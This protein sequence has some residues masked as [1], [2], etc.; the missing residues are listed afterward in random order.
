LNT[1]ALDSLAIETGTFNT[2]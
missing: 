2:L 1:T